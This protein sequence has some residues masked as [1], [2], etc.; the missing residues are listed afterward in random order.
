MADQQTACGSS[1]MMFDTKIGA[2]DDSQST[3]MVIV[4]YFLDRPGYNLQQTSAPLWRDPPEICKA[5]DVSAFLVD[6]V[7]DNELIVE[8]LLDHC[9]P[10]MLLEASMQG[11]Y[12]Q[13]DFSSTSLKEPGV[14]NIFLTDKTSECINIAAN[15]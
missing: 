2:S 14:L 11:Q 9:Q 15:G 13:F 6:I 8:I 12:C 4:R 7:Q 10:Y 5:S 3:H 1:T